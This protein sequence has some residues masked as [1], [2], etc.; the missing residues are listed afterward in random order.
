M[1]AD[2][3]FWDINNETV[4][5]GRNPIAGDVKVVR[6]THSCVWNTKTHEKLC[7]CGYVEATDTEA[8]VISG[9]DPENDHY[10]SLEFTV[11]DENDFTVWMDGS[12]AERSA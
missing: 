8:P 4:I 3:A 6:H 12:Q 1:A 2:R 11:T 9:I 7:G 10:G 5:D